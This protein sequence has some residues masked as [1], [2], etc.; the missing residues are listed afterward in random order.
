[1]GDTIDGLPDVSQKVFDIDARITERA[2]EGETIYLVVERKDDPSPIR[3]L[4]FDVAALAV[5]P[6]KPMRCKAVK[7]CRPTSRGSFTG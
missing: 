2:I 4:H 3:V 7:T 1:M 5:N 6:T